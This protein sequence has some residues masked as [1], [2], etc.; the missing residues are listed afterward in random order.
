MYLLQ[1]KLPNLIIYIV[2]R[3]YTRLMYIPAINMIV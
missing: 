3:F 1:L 2:N